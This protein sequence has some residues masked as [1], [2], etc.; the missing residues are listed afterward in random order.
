MHV[1]KLRQPN[2]LGW[3]RSGW[4][5]L[6]SARMIEPLATC[7]AYLVRYLFI[8]TPDTMIVKLKT[9]HLSQ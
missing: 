3:I 6:L 2:A 1:G 9:H 8:R 5:S 4:N 7:V